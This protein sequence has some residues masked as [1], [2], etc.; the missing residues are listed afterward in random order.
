LSASMALYEGIWALSSL[1]S[2]WNDYHSCAWGEK[3]KL[4]TILSGLNKTRYEIL[5]WM[6][7]AQDADQSRRSLAFFEPRLRD[8]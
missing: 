4:E 2:P 8:S 5:D 1:N 7:L 3:K 6:H